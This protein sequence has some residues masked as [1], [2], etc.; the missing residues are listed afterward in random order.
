MGTV[1]LKTVEAVAQGAPEYTWDAKPTAAEFGKGSVW[2]TDIGATGYSDGVNWSLSKNSPN[3]AMS[4]TL[5]IL[6]STKTGFTESA[7]NNGTITDSTAVKPDG[8][9]V[10]TVSLYT[11]INNPQ[12]TASITK[13]ISNTFTNDNAVPILFT[14]YADRLP[15]GVN[16]QLY[17][18]ISNSASL[19]SE[20]RCRGVL[21]TSFD[22]PGWN[23]IPID[24]RLTGND[25]FTGHWEQLGTAPF[26]FSLAAGS[27]RVQLTGD[28]TLDS[29]IARV[30]GLS[31]GKRERPKVCITFD[32]SKPTSYSI[33]YKEAKKRNLT[34]SH[35]AIFDS[36]GGTGMTLSQL[37]EIANDPLCYV[38]LHGNWRFDGA[39]SGAGTTPI[40]EMT[41]NINGLKAL[42][43]SDCQYLAW[44]EGQLGQY[45]GESLCVDVAKSLGVK[46]GRSTQKGYTFFN[47]GFYNPF[48]IRSIALNNTWTLA[49]AKEAVDRSIEWGCA[50]TFYAHDFGTAADSI[51]WVTQD[52]IDLLDY[53][54]TKKSIGLIDDMKFDDFM[55]YGASL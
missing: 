52:Y 40:G 37:T 3:K 34:T 51:T 55:R 45:V 17:P 7:T 5:S 9:V 25:S 6:T 32:D 2:F 53:I 39:G 26:D 54:A 11:P 18:L 43:L 24:K 27:Y 19:G 35:F 47:N 14:F 21:P 29:K 22:L 8:T 49:Q 41:R 36:L 48:A 46:G 4:N 30:Y 31:E 12:A 28:T 50:I 16:L 10:N 1:V 33:G 42:G 13:N 38:G 15:S 23:T 20:K 44:P